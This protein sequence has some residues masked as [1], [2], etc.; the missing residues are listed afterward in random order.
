MAMFKSED[1]F[2]DI[3]K[4]EPGTIPFLSAQERVAMIIAA[5]WIIMP[6][7]FAIMGGL[8]FFIV[9]IRYFL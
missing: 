5:L 1:I 6:Y 9:L 2:R 8:G 3:E 4:I 7:F